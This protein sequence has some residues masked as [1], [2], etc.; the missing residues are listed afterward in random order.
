MKS[1]AGLESLQSLN[2]VGAKI[3]DES[4]QLPWPKTLRSLYL[5]NT[6]VTVQGIEMLKRRLPDCQVVR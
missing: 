6:R 5:A 3:D 4:L 2:L 1:L